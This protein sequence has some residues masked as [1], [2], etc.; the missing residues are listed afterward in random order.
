[1][2]AVA[3][4]GWV[5]GVPYSIRWEPSPPDIVWRHLGTERLVEPFFDQTIERRRRD[6]D[7]RV[8][9]RV[10]STEGLDCLPA[11]RPP[12]GFIFH[13]SLCGST[14]VAHVFAPVPE[15]RVIYDEMIL[16]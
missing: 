7:N 3:G 4:G 13:T 14:L 15:H 12:A 9:D 16:S 1:M 2:G 6:P 11:V 5:G 10:T 8:H